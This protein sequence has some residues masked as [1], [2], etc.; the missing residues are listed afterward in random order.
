[1][2]VIGVSSQAFTTSALQKEPIHLPPF[3]SLLEYMDEA[4]KMIQRE[5][6]YSESSEDSDDCYV[7]KKNFEFFFKPRDI[8]NHVN[9][10]LSG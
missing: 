3:C 5:R 1:M 7:E 4:T 10:A 8:Q 2:P 6:K 9:L